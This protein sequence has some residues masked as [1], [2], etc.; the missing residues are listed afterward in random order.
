MAPTSHHIPTASTDLS[1]IKG[2]L[3]LVGLTGGIGSG[4]T[5]VSEQ[6]SN[7]GGGLVDSDLIAHEITAAGGIAIPPI[8]E[9]FGDRFIDSEG[10]LDRK[11]MRELVFIKPQARHLLEQITHPLIRKE[12]I[13]QALTIAR[14]GEA[15]YLVFVV[16]LLIESGVWMDIIDYLAVVDCPPEMQISRVMQRSNLSH[17]DAQNIL[18]AQ[19]SRDARLAKADFVIE[20]NASLDQLNLQVL[21]LHQKLLKLAKDLRSSA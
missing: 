20:N 19:I 12:A 7:L 4:K 21:N 5:M 2:R 1:S 14:S 10:A 15:P 6:L 17:I 3:L 13:A 11:K 8:R 9:E 18:N 16:P